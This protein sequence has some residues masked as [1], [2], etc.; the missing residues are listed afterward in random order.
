M[1]RKQIDYL[2]KDEYNQ[3]LKALNV[4]TFKSLKDKKQKLTN[5]FIHSGSTSSY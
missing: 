5:F 4:Q 3:G 2:I 1:Q